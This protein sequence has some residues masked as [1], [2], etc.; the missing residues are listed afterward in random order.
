MTLAPMDINSTTTD[1]LTLEYLILKT[2]V[3]MKIHELTY[4]LIIVRNNY[5]VTDDGMTNWIK[6]MK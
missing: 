6:L 1:W 4:H 2:D 5:S 3:I